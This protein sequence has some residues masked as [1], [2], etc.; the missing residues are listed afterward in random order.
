MSCN[1]DYRIYSWCLCLKIARQLKNFG[2]YLVN[3]LTK[4]K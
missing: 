1:W 2:G 3:I 4:E